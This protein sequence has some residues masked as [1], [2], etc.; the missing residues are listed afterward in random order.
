MYFLFFSVLAT[1]DAIGTMGC[2]DDS[3]KSSLFDIALPTWA[4]RINLSDQGNPNDIGLKIPSSGHV[5]ST[6]NL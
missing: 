1:Y 5:V 2:T 4:V 3:T 6:L